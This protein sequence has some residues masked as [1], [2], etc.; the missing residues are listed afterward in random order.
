VTPTATP[1]EP[2]RE[3]VSEERTKEEKEELSQ[4]TGQLIDAGQG[5]FT[6]I[7]RCG[8]LAPVRFSHDAIVRQGV[9]SK[10]TLLG[11][12][13][14]FVMELTGSTK[15]VRGETFV[16]YRE[17]KQVVHPVTGTVTGVAVLPVAGG[18]VEKIEGKL[19]SGRLTISYG[20][21]RSGDKSVFQG[22]W[23]STSTDKDKAGTRIRSVVV[24]EKTGRRLIGAGD[25]VYID[26]GSNDGVAAKDDFRIVK[27]SPTE[28][29]KGS[30][31]VSI[32]VIRILATLPDSSIGQVGW[33]REAVIPGDVVEK[34]TK[35]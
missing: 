11:L 26:K 2:V 4:G 3:T 15:V 18:V 35:E 33:S 30:S 14:R 27:D 22:Y 12:G 29:V 24:M 19:I 7:E 8:F 6:I 31:L 32:G 21:V 16:I 28:G 10:Q 13:D 23:R 20:A 25:I 34:V 5:S 1:T 17:V 9:E